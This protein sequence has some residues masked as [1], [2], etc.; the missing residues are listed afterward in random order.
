[1]LIKAGIVDIATSGQEVIVL[2]LDSQPARRS[3]RSL[4]VSHLSAFNQIS[5]PEVT[6]ITATRP[7]E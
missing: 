3:D 2:D 7:F 6:H 4:T 5:Q 1:M